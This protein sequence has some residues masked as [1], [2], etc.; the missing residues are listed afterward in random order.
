MCATDIACCA[1]G[2]IDDNV[3]AAADVTAEDDV[4]A[5]AFAAAPVLDSPL[6]LAP[7]RC[8]LSAPF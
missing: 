1:P 6:S 8:E 2:A 7:L 5:H 4:A 3:T